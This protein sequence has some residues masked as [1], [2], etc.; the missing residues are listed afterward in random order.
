VTIE[1]DHGLDRST[2]SA[3][4]GMVAAHFG[5]LFAHGSMSRILSKTGKG[6]FHYTMTWQ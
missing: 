1:A 2:F 3:D 6:R 4:P 5:A